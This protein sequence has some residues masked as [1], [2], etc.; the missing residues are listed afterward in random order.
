[1]LRSYVRIFFVLFICFLLEA[2]SAIAQ[3]K[4]VNK[5]TLYKSANEKSDIGD[6]FN[7]FKLYKTLYD[8]D[9]TDK[10][11]NYKMGVCYYNIKR[12]KSQSLKYFQRAKGYDSDELS[13]Y[14]AVNYQMLGDYDSA[15]E[16]FYTYQNANYEK[17]HSFKEINDQIAKCLYAKYAET[18]PLAD[19]IIENLG[20]SV[21]TEYSEYAPLIPADESSLIFTSKRVSSEGGKK[22]VYGEYYEDI[23]ISNRKNNQW[24]SVRNAGPTI[25]T[26]G[27]DACTGFSA[28][29][30]KIIIYISN[31][32]LLKG[33]FYTS[34][35]D[36]TN[37]K[38][39]QL[40]E[41]EIN[42]KDNTET[43][44]CYAP[45]GETV[46][47]SS[48]M[49]G[50]YGGKDLYMI[51]KL[52]NGKWGKP[53]NLGA[54]VNTSY[55]EDA[56]FIHPRNNMFFFSSQG[57][58]NNM[59]GYDIFQCAYNRDSAFF[60]KPENIGHPVNTCN[61]DIFFV[62]NTNGNTG[63]FSSERK[64][65]FGQADIYKVNFLSNNNNYTVIS[66][67]LADEEGNPIEGGRIELLDSATNKIIGT[68]KSNKYTG[69]FILIVEPDKQYDL[70]IYA[71][72][73]VM[74]TEKYTYRSDEVSNKKFILRK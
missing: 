51:K 8:T 71:A 20:D 35:F 11:I 27:N 16:Y 50:G 12:Y 56:P 48:D 61:D 70:S 66:C 31:D 47:F 28:D 53:Y 22:D 15:L 67:H 24:S 49:P 41:V 55:D 69:N 37:W 38:A 34:A 23:F 5:L 4:K 74:L 2:D 72:D 45:D 18:H 58:L 25:N 42:S 68:Y 44:A 57:Q 9:S 39:P 17:E 40:L 64:G 1:M 33:N 32:T 13:Y 3:F 60:P 6:Y 73:Y 59:G 26:S 65:G 14:L 46:F 29:G 52:P 19:I 21:N 7:A 30:Q 36:G 10:E 63:Y 54:N 43:S 62:L